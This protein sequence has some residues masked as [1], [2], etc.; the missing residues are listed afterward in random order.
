MS[1]SANPATAWT[2]AVAFLNYHDGGVIYISINKDGQIVGVSDP[3]ALQLTIKDHIKHNIQPSAPELFSEILSDRLKITSAD[4]IH[5][6]QEQEDFFADYSMPRNKTLM[7]M[8]KDLGMVEYLGSGMPHILKAL[9]GIVYLF[10]SLYSPKYACDR[11]GTSEVR[12]R[13]NPD[14]DAASTIRSTPIE[15]RAGQSYCFWQAEHAATRLLEQEMIEYTL[16]DKPNSR[17]QQY[18]LTEKGRMLS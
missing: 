4:I 17:L 9:R 8:F 14:S 2:G 13:V 16:P 7:R 5:P 1:T 11:R 3:N 18:R 6:S 10:C 12:A 15:V